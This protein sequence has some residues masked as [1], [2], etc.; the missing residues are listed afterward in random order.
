MRPSGAHGDLDLKSLG[1]I[2]FPDLIGKPMPPKTF[3]GRSG[4]SRASQ[5]SYSMREE[6]AQRSNGRDP[7]Q[8]GGKRQRVRRIQLATIYP[9][10]GK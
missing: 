2:A 7:E 9:G 3:D 5:V 1:L 4:I 8:E 6:F 10:S